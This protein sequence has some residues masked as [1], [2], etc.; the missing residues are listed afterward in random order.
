[1]ETIKTLADKLGMTV[2]AEGVETEEQHSH[3]RA[4][5]CE[6]AKGFRQT[7]RCGVDVSSASGKHVTTTQEP[8][9]STEREVWD[10]APKADPC[11]AA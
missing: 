6:Y 8:A 11:V 1:M 7:T 9:A 2:I 3:L 4:L 5:G 10:G